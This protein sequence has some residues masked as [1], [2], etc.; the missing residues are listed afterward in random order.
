MKLKRREERTTSKKWNRTS[1]HLCCANEFKLK[2]NEQP[3]ATVH[4]ELRGS[5]SG[6]RLTKQP[7]VINGFNSQ[8]VIENHGLDLR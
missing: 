3:P 2:F 8:A 6:V 1:H 7:G 5:H 4:T